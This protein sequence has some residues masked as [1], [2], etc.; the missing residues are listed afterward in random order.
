MTQDPKK[1][2]A[3]LRQCMGEDGDCEGCPYDGECGLRLDALNRDIMEYFD[4]I[5]TARLLTLDELLDLPIG[6][7]VWSESWSGETH[8]AEPEIL[9]ALR[10]DE[11]HL[12]DV[13]G[14]TLIDEDMLGPDVDGNRW[15]WWT[16]HPTREQREAAAWQK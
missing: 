2:A 4:A 3:A 10:V 8:S 1:M 13:D 16:L 15:R 6:A 11:S 9:P 7:V 14:Y 12:L 5:T